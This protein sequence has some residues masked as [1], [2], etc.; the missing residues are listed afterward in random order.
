MT[1]IILRHIL[2]IIKEENLI[3]N[4]MVQA[5]YLI[6]N[7]YENQKE[8][9]DLVSN[10]RGLGLMC[11]FDLPNRAVRDEFKNLCFKEKLVIMGCGE[12]SIRFRPALNITHQELN[13]GLQKMKKVLF[14][15]SVNK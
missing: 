3:A 5:N 8:F 10:A 6:E 15:L 12:R 1:L 13:R 4:V 14:L 11:S 2:N 7:L 9:P